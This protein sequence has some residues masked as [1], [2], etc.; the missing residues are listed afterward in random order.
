M[1]WPGNAAFAVSVTVDVDGEHGLP[2]GG[3]GYAHR[4]S[5]RSEREYGLRRGLP[6]VV[7]ILEE[8]GVLATFYVP[9][10]VATAHG[11]AVAQL[12]EAHHEVGHHGHRHLRP[13]R[14]SPAEQHEELSAGLDALRAAGARPVGYRAPG[15]EL[16]DATLDALAAHDL[17]H[18]SSLMGDDRPHRVS[19]DGRGIWE[20]PVHWTLDDAPHFAQGGDVDGLGRIWRAELVAARE[21]GRHVT[22]TLHPEILGRPHRAG[23][24]ARLLEDAAE[25]GAWIAPHAAV[26]QHLSAAS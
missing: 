7:R 12:L 23:A 5:A 11:D 15:W 4:L 1:N 8:A 21:E 2:H 18:D 20:L 17:T 16:T 24:L 25:M 19:S 13:D 3:A 9:G 22:Y 10:A 26:V 6:R 14:L